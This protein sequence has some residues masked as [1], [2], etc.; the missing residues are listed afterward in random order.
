M[1]VDVND[2]R[3]MLE[4]W[5]D[6]DVNDVNTFVHHEH[7]HQHQDAHCPQAAEETNDLITIGDSDTISDCSNGDE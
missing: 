1:N 2:D 4:E 5:W 6:G 3:H 7:Q